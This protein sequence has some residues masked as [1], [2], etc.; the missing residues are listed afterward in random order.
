MRSIDG[1]GPR[2]IGVLGNSVGATIAE[3]LAARSDGVAFAVVL[4]CPAS[5]GAEVMA[6]QTEQ[7]A[8][9]LPGP[10]WDQI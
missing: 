7:I 4:G 6:W 3:R 5:S 10:S 2:R 9:G 8:D 1:I